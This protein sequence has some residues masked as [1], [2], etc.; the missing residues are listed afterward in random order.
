LASSL[1]T[2]R[3][4]SR[5]RSVNRMAVRRASNSFIADGEVSGALRIP[6]LAPSC[7]GIARLSFGAD[8]RR[9][10][11]V[12]MLT[13]VGISP[14]IFPT[15]LGRAHEIRSAPMARPATVDA[16]T[17]GRSFFRRWRKPCQEFIVVCGA[18]ASAG[19]S[20][21]VPTPAAVFARRGQR[22]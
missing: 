7:D 14:R 2:T 13:S 15:R 3:P 5:R 8:Y 11:T 21:R 12:G 22:A 10:P 1:C 17:R 9:L 6:E 20:P 16:D 4:Q 18:I 19:N